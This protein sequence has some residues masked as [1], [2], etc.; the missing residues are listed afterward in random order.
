VLLLLDTL[1]EAMS[2]EKA[3]LADAVREATLNGQ[4]SEVERLLAKVKR[5]ES[6]V[7]Q[8]IRL[9]EA[10]VRLDEKVEPTGYTDMTSTDDDVTPEVRVVEKLFGVRPTRKRQ[11]INKTPF[12]VLIGCRFLSRWNSW[13]VGGICGKC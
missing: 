13:A 2:N 3:Q 6:L 11:R 4:F 12:N 8:V 9:R 10:W 5:V 1:L 7:K